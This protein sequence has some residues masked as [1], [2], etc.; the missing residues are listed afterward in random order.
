MIVSPALFVE[1][2]L[3]L[4]K[5]F[6]ENFQKN[7]KIILQFLKKSL[8]KEVKNYEKVHNCQNQKN[9]LPVLSFLPKNA[10]S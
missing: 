4:L 7:E 3:S 10:N 1:I 9:W 5:F 2:L 8:K 6:V